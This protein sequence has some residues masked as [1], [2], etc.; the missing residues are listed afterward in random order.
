MRVWFAV[1]G[2]FSPFSRLG[3][4]IRHWWSAVNIERWVMCFR[5]IFLFLAYFLYLGAYGIYTS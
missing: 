3:V 2:F 5:L 4:F 1:D